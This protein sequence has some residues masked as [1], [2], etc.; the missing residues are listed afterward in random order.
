MM[1]GV[2]EDLFW[3]VVRERKNLDLSVFAAVSIIP[4]SFKKN[5]SNVYAS[6]AHIRGRISAHEA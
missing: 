4:L 2:W 5:V 3:W 6:V 1:S